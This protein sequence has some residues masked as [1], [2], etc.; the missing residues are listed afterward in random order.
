MNTMK[1]SGQITISGIREYSSNIALVQSDGQE[2]TFFTYTLLD[3]LDS[4]RLRIAK[5]GFNVPQQVK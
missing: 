1:Y 3:L 5:I 2:I 4:K